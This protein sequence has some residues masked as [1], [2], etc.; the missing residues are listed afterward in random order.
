MKEN[1]PKISYKDIAKTTPREIQ[2]IVCPLSLDT[3]NNK[4]EITKILKNIYPESYIMASKKLRDGKLNL[5]DLY[6]YEE[7]LRTLAYIPVRRRFTD[8]ISTESLKKGMESLGKYLLR[9]QEIKTVGIPQMAPRFTI[10]DTKWEDIKP[11]IIRAIASINEKV[12]VTIF[13]KMP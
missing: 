5:G 12:K 3:F 11:T 13:E 4:L 7:N 6:C 2:L 8:K 1:R 10:D 9:H